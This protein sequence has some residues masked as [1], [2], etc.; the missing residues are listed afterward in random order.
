MS[1][2]Q[3]SVDERI[4]DAW[5]R[6]Q[7][8]EAIIENIQRKGDGI[9]DSLAEELQSAQ[10]DYAIAKDDRSDADYKGH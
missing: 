3:Q 8:Y 10:I 6:I 9:P 4:A 5:N 2:K 7:K 1:S